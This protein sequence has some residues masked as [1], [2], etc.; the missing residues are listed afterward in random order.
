ME[1]DATLD[2]FGLLRPMPI[3]KRTQKMQELEGG[4]VLEILATVPGYPRGY[5]A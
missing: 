4:E 2:T 1:A 3:I 5:P